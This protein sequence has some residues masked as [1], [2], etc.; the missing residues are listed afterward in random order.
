M[1]LIYHKGAL[2][3]INSVLVYIAKDDAAAVARVV[4]RIRQV[5]ELLATSPFLGRPGRRGARF[6]SIAGLPYVIIYR[7]AGDSV[8]IMAVFH[9]ARNRRF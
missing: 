5:A 7:V 1:K 6:L 8:R 4:D 2:R 9:T 3:D